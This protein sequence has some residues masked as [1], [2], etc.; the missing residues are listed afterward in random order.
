MG[1]RARDYPEWM[2]TEQARDTLAPRSRHRHHLT[3]H[4]PPKAQAPSRSRRPIRTWRG[5]S[6][7]LLAQLPP[8]VPQI[9]RNAAGHRLR[10]VGFS[11]PSGPSDRRLIT[12]GCGAKVGDRTAGRSPDTRMAGRSATSRRIVAVAWR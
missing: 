9:D 10:T 2:I 1:V 3:R 4:D 8:R 5:I 7:S 11:T 6:P 12:P